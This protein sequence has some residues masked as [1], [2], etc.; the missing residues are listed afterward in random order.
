MEKKKRLWESRPMPNIGHDLIEIATEPSSDHPP[1][2]TTFHHPSVTKPGCNT[3]S[4]NYVDSSCEYVSIRN[5]CSAR[6]RASPTSI[7]FLIPAIP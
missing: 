3:N 2:Y 6:V 7:L 1:T 4:L 5:T